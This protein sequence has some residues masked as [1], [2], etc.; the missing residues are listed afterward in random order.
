MLKCNF[1]VQNE[2]LYIATSSP[3]GQ[4]ALQTLSDSLLDAELKAFSGQ[5]VSITDRQLYQITLWQLNE[6][7]FVLSMR[8]HHA[9]IDGES[10]ALFS[11]RILARYF[12]E[13]RALPSN[14][15]D[16]FDYALFVSN[17]QTADTVDAQRSYWTQ[18]LDSYQPLG[19]LPGYTPLAE[20]NS[21]KAQPL[22]I[23]KYQATLLQSTAQHQ[24]CSTLGLLHTLFALSLNSLAG[25]N[26]LL[27]A[28]PVSG[29]NDQNLDSVLG[30]FA[31]TQLFR[32]QINGNVSLSALM[33]K[34]HSDYLQGLQ[35]LHLPIGE[36]AAL[37]PSRPKGS[38][39][40]F[41]LNINTQQDSAA[42]DTGLTVSHIPQALGESLFDITLN[43]T[44]TEQNWQCH[45]HYN[46]KRV[47]DGLIQ[48]LSEQLHLWIAYL[49]THLNT[50]VS[51]LEIVTAKERALVNSSN[52]THTP[53][54]GNLLAH[55]AAVSAKMPDKIA[56]EDSEANLT[57]RAL[58]QRAKRYTGAIAASSNTP[59][60]RVGIAMTPSCE[61]IAAILGCMMAGAAYLP[62]DKQYPRQRLDYMVDSAELDLVI[63]DEVQFDEVAMLMTAMVDEAQ[64]T[65]G[66]ITQT[67]EA[68]QKAYLIF[69]SGT[70]GKPK[71][72]PI[73]H[74][75][76]MNL[77]VAQSATFELNANSRVLQMANAGFDAAVSE[78]AIALYSGATLVI[79]AREE[80]QDSTRLQSLLC[81]K[82]IT[83]ITLPPALMPYINVASLTT[84][85][86]VVLAGQA[87]QPDIAKQWSAHCKV[88]NA[89]GPSEAAVCTTIYQ[90]DIAGKDVPIGM[91][92]SNMRCY[93]VNP[94][95]QVCPAYVEGEILIGGTG[96]TSGYL[97]N[98]QANQ[99][100]FIRASF[101]GHSGETLYRSGDIGFY[102]ESGNIHFVGRNDEQV[103]LNGF[104]IELAEIEVVAKLHAEIIDAKAIIIDAKA[105]Q[106]LTLM[107]AAIQ[108]TFDQEVLYA[109]LEQYLPNFML[110]S[111][112]LSLTSLP[113]TANGKHDLDKLKQLALGQQS[114][115][116]SQPRYQFEQDIAAIWADALDR[117]TIGPDCDFF[118]IG[119]NSLTASQVC[120]RIARHSN[121]DISARTLFM[122]SSL[123]E[124]CQHL[125]VTLLLSGN[126]SEQLEAY[127]NDVPEHIMEQ[128][129]IKLER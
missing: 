39:I 57:Y 95:M 53:V 46:S 19:N 15:V 51:Q 22:H 105:G 62:L 100:K 112:I 33:N 125:L 80:K 18:Y 103:K 118:K 72:I 107:V 55:I 8:F 1:V 21:A 65:Q 113:T 87:C 109:H 36:I 2:S 50:P 29:R 101:F 73:T 59:V 99:D 64:E 35:H 70:T 49:D 38:A 104:R 61:S 94:L 74:V 9:L 20:G 63:S 14:E 76:L 31:T 40:P 77:A 84:L 58:L 114:L 34:T 123:D 81:N 121:I 66:A 126:D 88:F 93:I 47:T 32:H 79:P 120:A 92:I 108:Q 7:K 90:G 54:Q 11:A 129:S 71:G 122:H 41:M 91:P 106:Q 26:D 28:S 116:T 12:D 89:Y 115:P 42:L 117:T 83:H 52:D 67:P 127:L 96:L 78:W 44:I 30:F 23:D 25:G 86:H 98:A 75:A 82:Q 102:D 68:H 3:S 97:H 110:P 16:F 5:P 119:G 6:D 13:Q 69:T 111:T 27:I 37:L 60:K 4:F 17:Q 48:R 85:S 128:L 43:V 45:W 10:L 24:R 56:V 124:F